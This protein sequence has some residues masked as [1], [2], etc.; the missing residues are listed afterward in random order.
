MSADADSSTQPPSPPVV[1]E[2]ERRPIPFKG[3]AS[4]EFVRRLIATGRYTVNTLDGTPITDWKRLFQDIHEPSAADAL[5][6]DKPIPVAD[7]IQPSPP[8]I[9]VPRAAPSPRILIQS[10]AVIVGNKKY[11]NRQLEHFGDALVA[12]TGRVMVHELCSTDQRL[13][14][15]FSGQLIRNKNL[16]HGDTRRGSAAEVEIGLC[17]VESGFDAAS[18]CARAIIEKTES[19]QNLV[20]FMESKTKS[21]DKNAVMNEV[22]E[23]EFFCL[24]GKWFQWR[25]MGQQQKVKVR[26][27]KVAIAQATRNEADEKWWSNVR[28]L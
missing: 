23:T 7:V 3:K 6:G 26:Q 12:L 22:K 13:Y 14:F 25:D 4:K 17:Y 10:P 27:R 19:W 28:I 16:G 20:K 1:P 2:Y 24:D 5:D 21:L 18:E 9:Q 8:V 15:D 11:T